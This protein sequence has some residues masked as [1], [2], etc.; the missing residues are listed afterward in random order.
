VR[1]VEDEGVMTQ[2]YD[3][4]PASYGSRTSPIEFNEHNISLVTNILRN[5]EGNTPMHLTS[6]LGIRMIIQPDV[7]TITMRNIVRNYWDEIYDLMQEPDISKW[8]DLLEDRS[9]G[10]LGYRM[11]EFLSRR[12][13]HASCFTRS[14]NEMT[15]FQKELRKKIEER[16]RQG[17]REVNVAIFGPGFMQEAIEVLTAKDAVLFNIPGRRKKNFSVRI[18]VFDYDGPDGMKDKILANNIYYDPRDIT[19]LR[20]TGVQIRNYFTRDVSRGYRLKDEHHR[21]FEFQFVDFN[22]LDRLE[23]VFDFNKQMDFIFFNESFSY[24][25]NYKYR[26]FMELLHRFLNDDGVFYAGISDKNF[27]TWGIPE[28]PALDDLWQ[29]AAYDL[30]GE[31]EILDKYYKTGSG[32]EGMDNLFDSMLMRLRCRRSSP[33]TSW[34]GEVITNDR[35]NALVGA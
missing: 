20:R 21:Q 3:F 23:S 4:F 18:K 7:N 12:I 30:F 5:H 6:K 26:R 24:I 32:H 15:D 33:I 8:A 16:I 35:R 2:L 17:A 10:A 9:K 19:L 25:K 27:A 13:R 14:A 34:I 28:E 31:G 29:L 11:L 22:Q 1:T